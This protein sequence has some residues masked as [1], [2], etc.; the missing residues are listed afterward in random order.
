MT[1]YLLILVALF[2]IAIFLE[3]KFHMHLYKSRKERIIITIIFLAFGIIWDSFAVWRGHWTFTGSGLTGIKIGLI[4]LE[5]YLFALI[6][7]YFILTVHK[8]LTRRI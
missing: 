8:F 6:I 7:P 2:L 5:E 1:E 3:Y 4:P